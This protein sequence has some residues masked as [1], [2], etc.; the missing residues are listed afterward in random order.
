[1]KI[2]NFFFIVVLAAA[3]NAIP[4][5]PVTIKT[6]VQNAKS[7][8]LSDDEIK[9]VVDAGSSL[10]DGQKTLVKCI[11]IADNLVSL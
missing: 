8:G 1:M 2:H 3:A 6:C 5:G 11:L 7:S 9:S 4:A 10:S